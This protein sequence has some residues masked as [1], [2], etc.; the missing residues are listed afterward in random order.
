MPY[1][2]PERKRQWDREHPW[3]A[4]RFAIAREATEWAERQVSILRS[5]GV[6]HTHEEW[7]ALLSDLR[8]S[9]L[10]GGPLKETPEYMSRS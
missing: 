7:R 1:R 6:H 2:D 5:T 8:K 3:R 9:R 10:R 4:E